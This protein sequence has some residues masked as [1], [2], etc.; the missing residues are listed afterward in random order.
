M[1]GTQSLL[2]ISCCPRWMRGPLAL[3]AQ[4]VVLRAAW[5]LETF[6]S[7]SA[8]A[9]SFCVLPQASPVQ[10]AECV[11]AARASEGLPSALMGLWRRKHFCSCCGWGSPHLPGKRRVLGRRARGLL[12]VE[13]SLGRAKRP[14][15][16]RAA[17]T[18]PGQLE[19]LGAHG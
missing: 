18:C 12:A 1:P 5:A 11:G 4:E 7:S 2:T 17:L 9:A 16:R 19:P 10:D 15:L 14:C 3:F 13:P 8:H 6:R